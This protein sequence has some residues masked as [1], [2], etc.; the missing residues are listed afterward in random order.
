MEGWIVFISDIH[1]EATEE[2]LSDSFSEY[3]DIKNM[4]VNLDR[5]TGFLKVSLACHYTINCARA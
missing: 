1:E 3:G 4:H 2:D 5:R